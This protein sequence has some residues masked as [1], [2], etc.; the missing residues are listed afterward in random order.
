MNATMYHPLP[1]DQM[2]PFHCTKLTNDTQSSINKHFIVSNGKTFWT[3]TLRLWM[4][5]FNIVLVQGTSG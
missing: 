5:K 4:T 2:P 3:K 1:Y